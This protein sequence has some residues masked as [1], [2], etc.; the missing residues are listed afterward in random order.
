MDGRDDRAPRGSRADAADLQRPAAG[1]EARHRLC[2][3][4]RRGEQR[5]AG[6]LDVRLHLRRDDDI[7]DRLPAAPE[8][9]VADGRITLHL[10][11]GVDVRE[12]AVAPARAQVQPERVVHHDLVGGRDVG[13]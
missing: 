2:V 10:P 13:A 6:R 9:V 1:V 11:V 7:L 5:E 8:D 3:V 4:E 12:A